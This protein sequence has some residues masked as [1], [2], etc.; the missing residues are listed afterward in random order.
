VRIV[1]EPGSYDSA[2]L[3]DT[4]MLAVALER[5]RRLWPDAEVIVHAVDGEAL[6][7]VDAKA[8]L[9]DPYGSIAWSYFHSPFMARLALA[10]KRRRPRAV[11]EY[12]DAV[13]GADLVLASGG[14]FLTDVFRRRALAVLDTL[15]LAMDAG[16]VAALVGQGI[17]P[18][19]D[20][21][22]RRRAAEVLP[23]AG[24]IAVREGLAAVPL[25]ESI[26]VPTANIRVTGD[27][28]IALAYRARRDTPGDALGVN[29]RL[30]PYAGTTAADNDRVQRVAQGRGVPLVP[31]SIA[32]DDAGPAPTSI[33][34]LLDVLPSCRVVIAGSYHAAVFA[35][36]M[37]IPAIAI[38]ASAYYL[39]KFR[40]LASQFGP[41]CRL[42][43]MKEP[44]FERRLNDA[45]DETWQSDVRPALLDAA[46]KQIALGEA[47]F[48]EIQNAE[49]QE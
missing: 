39:D 7:A 14:G 23:R 17:G 27:D 16:A 42:V 2:N 5:L 30:A 48:A 36:S 37:G 28:A 8:R 46:R 34:Q 12:L 19:T 18:M 13:R 26:G 32:V 4:A 38:A 24:L 31:V 33:E 40:G 44:D 41:A 25:L 1:I 3:G 35:L 21:T 45:I 43:L 9:L 10:A 15:E 29:V 6:S 47:A 11:R 22:L 49:T 20:R